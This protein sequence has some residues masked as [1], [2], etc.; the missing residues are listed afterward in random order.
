MPWVYR[1]E[2]DT[3]HHGMLSGNETAEDIAAAQIQSLYP[4]ACASKKRHGLRELCGASFVAAMQDDDAELL[5]DAGAAEDIVGRGFL[6][7]TC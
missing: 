5:I 4:P 6:P 3:T 1:C 7:G 2:V